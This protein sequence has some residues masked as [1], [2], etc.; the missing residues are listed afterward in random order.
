MSGLLETCP[1]PKDDRI[2]KL[3]ALLTEVGAGGR[4]EQKG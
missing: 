4:S 2:H 1:V 3:P